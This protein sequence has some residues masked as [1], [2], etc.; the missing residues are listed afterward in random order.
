V[1]ASSSHEAHGPLYNGA[2]NAR[3]LFAEGF[4]LSGQGG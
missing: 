3:D 1:V 2:T 4:C